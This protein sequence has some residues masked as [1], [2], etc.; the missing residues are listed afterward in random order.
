MQSIRLTRDLV[1]L[2][3][4]KEEAED[5]VGWIDDLEQAIPSVVVKIGNNLDELW[6]K[7]GG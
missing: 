4:T 5:L 2:F 7:R 1:G 6:N 3:L